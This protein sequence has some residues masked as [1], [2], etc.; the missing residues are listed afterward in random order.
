MLI[1]TSIQRTKMQLPNRKGKSNGKY[2][3]NVCPRAQ[4]YSDK[5]VQSD[6]VKKK[7][8]GIVDSE[9]LMW[10]RRF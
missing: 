6:F 10:R 9:L 7:Q 8:A 3:I 4:L 5:D 1:D 2:I